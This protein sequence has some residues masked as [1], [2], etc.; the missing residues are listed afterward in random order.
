MYKFNSEDLFIGYLKQLLS[1]FNLPKYRV[2]TKADADYNKLA[3][4]H[5]KK[6]D[7]GEISGLK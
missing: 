5:N 3:I 4:E 6:V 7:S 1:S 2:Y